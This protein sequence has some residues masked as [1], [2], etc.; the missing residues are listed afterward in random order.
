MLQ[1]DNY[2][3]SYASA[4]IVAIPQRHLAQGMYWL[5]GENGSGKTT[6]LKSIAGLIPFDGTITVAD[7]TIRKQRMHYKRLVNYA[8]AEPVYPPFLT[9]TELLHFYFKT[10]GGS[11][12]QVLKLMKVL[13]VDKYIDA[14][15]STCSSGMLKKLSLLFA[16]VGAPKLMLLDEPLI[17]LDTDSV[18]IL[19]HTIAHF[20][21][22][23]VSFLV[24]SHQ[25][26]TNSSFPV[27]TLLL[28]DGILI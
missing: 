4:T 15:V 6:V 25:E 26:F 12:A 16:F 19:Q 21:Q 22:A 5:Q 18:E 8:E 23:G 28:K 11:K 3:K 9:G 2:K 20:H 1:F 24:T 13:G 14:K 7:T 27:S 10:K 17:T